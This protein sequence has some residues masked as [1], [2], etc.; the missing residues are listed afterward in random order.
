[1]S[2]MGRAWAEINRDAL[3]SNI[4][5]IKKNTKAELML[6]VKADGYG[7]GAASVARIGQKCG[8]GY[9]GVACAN[10]AHSLREAG[11]DLPMLIVGGVSPEDLTT[12][13]KCNADLTVFSLGSAKQIN[14]AAEYLGKKARVHIK[15]D[16]GM[17]RLGFCTDELSEAEKIAGF[18]NLQIVGAFT[19]FAKADEPDKSFTI[20]QYERFIDFTDKLKKEGIE[21]PMLHAC[22]SAAS[23]LYP[24]M[25]LDMIRPGIAIYG[26]YPSEY[27]KEASHIKLQR[28]MTIK[29]KLM[30]IHEISEGTAVSYGGMFVAD[31]K[32][33]IGTIAI[34][35]GDGYSR[36]MSDKGIAVVNGQPVKVIGRVCM[37]QC[38]VDLSDVDAHEGD[39]VIMLGD[40]FT[41][42]DI[43]KLDDTICYETYCLIGKRLPRIYI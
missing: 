3:R 27:V 2:L 40:E 21:I 13:I 8:A 9:L 6:M 28:A 37:D 20:Q 26:S 12:A 29:A 43:A 39:E 42:E 23:L 1:M 14:D 35:Y 7:H 18:K 33:K 11:A 41:A 24:E 31:K 17:S 34:G 25:H 16:T 15:I 5:E 4:E 10:E 19:H 36:A 22:N 32:M 30:Q 38:M